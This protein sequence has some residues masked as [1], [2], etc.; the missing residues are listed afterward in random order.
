MRRERINTE[1][2]YLNAMYAS[3]GSL[4]PVLDFL[5][6]WSGLEIWVDNVYI[7]PGISF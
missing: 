2:V 3:Q 1:Y 5:Q 7:V 4:P 6:P